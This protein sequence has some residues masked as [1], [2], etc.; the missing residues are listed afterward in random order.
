MAVVEL[1]KCLIVLMI[2]YFFAV[3]FG[4]LASVPMVAHVYPQS[5]CM[6]FAFAGQGN[7]LSYGHYASKE[8]FMGIILSFE[9]EFD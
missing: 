7:R 1:R 9:I 5:E 4:F 2:V 8:W 6:L 3:A